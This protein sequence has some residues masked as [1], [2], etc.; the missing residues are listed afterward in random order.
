MAAVRNGLSLAY[1]RPHSQASV[2]ARPKNEVPS[3]Y[4][5]P[6]GIRYNYSLLHWYCTAGSYRGTSW[7]KRVLDVTVYQ[8]AV[9]RS[10][11]IMQ[12]IDRSID[13]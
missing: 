11:R 10:V 5:F 12:M 6:P 7:G 2:R 13:G 3:P 8:N 1:T 9:K 4:P